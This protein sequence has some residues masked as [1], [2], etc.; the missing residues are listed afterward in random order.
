V[1]EGQDIA[2]KISKVPRGAQ[3]KPAKQVVLE[4]VSIDRVA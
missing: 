1:I 2:D 3:D 4:S